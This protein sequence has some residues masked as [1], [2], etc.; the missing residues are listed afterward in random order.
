MERVLNLMGLTNSFGASADFSG[1]T[2]TKPFF[3]T[4]V[5]HQARLGID[6][7]GTV[8]TAATELVFSDSAGPEPVWKFKADHP[9]MYLIH[10]NE[11]GAIVFMGRLSDPSK[12]DRSGM[13]STSQPWHAGCQKVT[14]E[15]VR[16]PKPRQLVAHFVLCASAVAKATAR[17]VRLLG[18]SAALARM[19]F[20]AI[21]TRQWFS[22]R[23]R[24]WRRPSQ[25]CGCKD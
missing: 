16:L 22:V 18:G 20:H 21:I 2:K 6:E 12:V 3:I 1:I 5:F 9:F 15:R 17:Q 10:D 8:A 23:F 24:S 14:L 19:G 4:K 11:T 7:A 13:N 25:L